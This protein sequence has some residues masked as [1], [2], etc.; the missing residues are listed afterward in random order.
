MYISQEWQE[1]WLVHSRSGRRIGYCTPG[2]AAD[3]LLH[4]NSGR[5]IGYCTPGVA[6]GLLT[7][8]GAVNG[9][10]P[11]IRRAGDERHT[12]ILRWR[13]NS[14]VAEVLQLQ[15]SLSLIIFKLQPNSELICPSIATVIE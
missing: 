3:W 7:A 13:P 2:V 8:W 12:E 15:Q 14:Y 5:R 10:H 9:R 4:S 11:K 6:G 1:V